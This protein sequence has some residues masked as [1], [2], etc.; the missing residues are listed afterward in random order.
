MSS[1][2]AIETL[3]ARMAIRD[4]LTRYCRGIDRLDENL[5]ASAYWPDATEDHGIFKGTAREFAPWIVE[6]LDNSFLS[7][8]HRLGQ[9]SVVLRGDRAA[10]ET[11]FSSI[12][13]RRAPDGTIYE[14]CDGRYVDNF[15]KRGATWKISSRLVVVDYLRDFSQ[16][17]SYFEKIPGL[18]IGARGHN[19]VSYSHF[20]PE[21]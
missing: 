12:H 4:S 13:R 18:T 3:L 11:Y 9:S 10:A 2:A 17:S 7:T 6:F 5:I 1:S 8:A 14:A 16:E 20:P 19:D 21:S 15:E